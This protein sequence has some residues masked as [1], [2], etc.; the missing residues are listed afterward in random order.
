VKGEEEEP[1]PVIFDEFQRCNSE[2]IISDKES[3]S[4]ISSDGEFVDACKINVFDE[5]DSYIDRIEQTKKDKALRDSIYRAGQNF[6]AVGKNPILPFH[7]LKKPLYSQKE[8]FMHS[9][10]MHCYS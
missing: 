9:N 6:A 8:N 3:D 10:S 7:S 4:A 2:Y 5:D 1:T